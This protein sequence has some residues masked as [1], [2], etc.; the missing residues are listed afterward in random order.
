MINFIRAFSIRGLLPWCLM[1]ML[2]QPSLAD[3]PASTILDYDNVATAQNALTVLPPSTSTFHAWEGADAE[4]QK[5][6]TAWEKEPITIAWTRIQLDRY[7]KHKMMPTRGARGLALVHVAMHDALIIAEQRRVSGRLAVSMAAAQVLAY[8]FPAEERGFDRI[9]LSAAARLNNTG[10][11]TLPGHVNLA[12]AIGQKVGERVIE[13]AEEDGAQRGWNG[14][15]L[16]WYGDGRYYGPGTWEP[17]PPYFY[18]PPDEPF[19]P[20]WRTWTL[21]TSGEFRPVPPA[22]GSPKF[23]EDLKEVVSTNVALSR[24]QLAVAK[25]WVDGHGSVTPPGHWNQIAIEHALKHQLDDMRAARLFAQLNIAEADAFIATWDA[26]YHFWTMRP[27][28]AAKYVLGVDLKPAVL[29]P[30]FPSYPSGHATF[31]GAAAEV[32]SSYFPAE[33]KKLR[34][35]AAEAAYSRL[36]GGIHYRHDNEDGLALGRRVAQRVLEKY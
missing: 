10:P 25:F 31:S 11:E 7:V 3:A 1:L 34:A 12:L 4:A 22:F 26:K 9:A 2:A 5:I 36:L 18:Y 35:M 33:A 32:L 8:L 15:R 14:V 23:L 19:A 28:T 30:P 13:Y 29:T 21:R 20:T 24:A 6:V 27:V 17:T 16:Q